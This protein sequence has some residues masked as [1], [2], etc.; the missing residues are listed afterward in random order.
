MEWHQWVLWMWDVGEEALR[1]KKH[2]PGQ[3]DKSAAVYGDNIHQTATKWQIRTST[4]AQLMNV[5]PHFVPVSLTFLGVHSCSQVS[6]LCSDEESAC[7]EW[8]LSPDL[9]HHH[10]AS[11]SGDCCTTL[12]MSSITDVIILSA[13]ILQTKPGCQ[14]SWSN[15]EPQCGVMRQTAA[16]LVELG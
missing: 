14:G 1:G 4:Y 12:V 2:F 15:R 13:L 6:S 7:A 10:Q 3:K 8:R 5:L 11:C 9:P 16:S